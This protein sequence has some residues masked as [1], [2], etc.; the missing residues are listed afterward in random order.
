MRVVEIMSSG[1]IIAI[2]LFLFVQALR[3][4]DHSQTRNSHLLAVAAGFVPCPL[5]S[6]IMPY[7]V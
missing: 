5:T 7:A 6:F 2:G 3:G 1:L 4:H